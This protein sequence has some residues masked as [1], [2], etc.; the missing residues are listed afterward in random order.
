MTRNQIMEETYTSEKMSYERAA[1]L[2]EQALMI[3]SSSALYWED[4][5]TENLI[6]TGDRFHF[7]YEN[8]K[9]FSEEVCDNGCGS[10]FGIGRGRR[11]LRIPLYLRIILRTLNNPKFWHVDV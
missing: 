2:L 1:N 5:Q 11:S 10:V 7:D 6:Y 8:Q 3:E 9:W 4:E